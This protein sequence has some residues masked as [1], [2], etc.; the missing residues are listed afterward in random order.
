MPARAFQKSPEFEKPEL[1]IS[2]IGN[3][4]MTRC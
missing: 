3:L 2:D 4:S 1:E